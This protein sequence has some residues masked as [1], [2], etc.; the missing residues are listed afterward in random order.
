ML[1]SGFPSQLARVG[2][3]PETESRRRL[4]TSGLAAT[5]CPAN[6]TTKT[7]LPMN[8]PMTWRLRRLLGA[9]VSCAILSLPSGNA[10]AEGAAITL[11]DLRQRTQQLMDAIAPGD[12]KPW[13]RAI[14]E[15]AII[16][17]ETGR[18]MDKRS[19]LETIT[20]LP[21]GYGGSIKIAEVNARF[22]PRTAVLSYD[23][24]ESETIFGTE[25]HARYHYTDTWL[26]RNERWQIVA[27]Q[28][29]RY[30]EDPA[31]IQLTASQLDDYVGSYQM[32]PGQVITI[33]RQGAQLY[34]QRE[35]GAPYELQAEC[36]DLFFRPG[37]EGRRLFHRDAS[38]RVDSMVSR[39]NNEDVLWRRLE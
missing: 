4:W 20:G 26:Y 28:A 6:S 23:T 35:S 13:Q 38:G 12:K 33:T 5:L 18:R 1:R 2:I 17:D 15:D 10:H 11:T 24:N 16:V 8:T 27:S 39:R 25:L 32:A 31:S 7:L 36:R 9:T 34:V 3:F 37:V 19:F 29:L 30:Y 14:A 22:A 21:A